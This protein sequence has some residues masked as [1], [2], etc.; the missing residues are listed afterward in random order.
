MSLAKYK[1]APADV[2]RYAIDYSDWLDS[3]ETIDSVSFA[4]S[5][6]GAL[7]VPSNEI[8]DDELSVT[9]FV[10]GGNDGVTYRVVV[11]IVTSGG[12]IKEDLILFVV[13]EL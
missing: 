6:S 7:S 10:S 1:K 5:P 3:G 8:S 11:T 12:Q 13:R 4:V 9:Y 2:K